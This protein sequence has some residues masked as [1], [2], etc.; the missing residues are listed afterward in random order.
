MMEI[1]LALLVL[2]LIWVFWLEILLMFRLLLLL[3]RL[4]WLLLMFATT[5]ATTLNTDMT[6]QRKVI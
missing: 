6:V 5:L 4:F 1:V 3:F 2:A